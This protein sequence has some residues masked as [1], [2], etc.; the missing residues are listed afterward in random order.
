[1]S[2]K[3]QHIN[4]EPALSSMNSYNS[5]SFKTI[6]Q[7][8]IGHISQWIIKLIPLSQKYFWV[9]SRPL[10]VCQGPPC[11]ASQLPPIERDGG[12]NTR[13]ITF[14][15]DLDHWIHLTQYIDHV[16]DFSCHNYLSFKSFKWRH[17]R[18]R[19]QSS[20]WDGAE[21]S[22]SYQSKTATLDLWCQNF[23]ALLPYFI[24]H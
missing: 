20:K 1:M 15:S 14:Q 22:A 18:C 3:S 11:L 4:F 7:W 5:Y 6:Q 9:V 24:W 23:F 12:V 17:Q 21:F 10:P 8:P 2:S 19:K 13:T 16:F